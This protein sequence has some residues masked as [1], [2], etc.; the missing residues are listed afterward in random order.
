MG[1]VLMALGVFVRQWSILTLGRFFTADV[2]VSAR[3]PVI[4]SG[5]YRWV[6]HPSYTG[7]IIFSIGFALALT[8]F[9]SLAIL[10]VVPTIGLIARIHFEERALV[11]SLGEP[12]SRYAATHKRLIPGVW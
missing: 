2:R 3:Q 5:P 4:D 11:A 7:L 6:R 1:L 9:I 12:Y 8:N 10:A